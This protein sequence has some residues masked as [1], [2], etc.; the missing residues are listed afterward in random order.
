MC[1]R[2][3]FSSLL[4]PN[5]T[6]SHLL[7]FLSSRK[8]AAGP[9]GQAFEASHE[10]AQV[11][12]GAPRRPGDT[13]LTVSIR[14]HWRRLRQSVDRM[15]GETYLLCFGVLVFLHSNVLLTLVLFSEVLANNEEASEAI[16]SGAADLF[17]GMNPYRRSILT[18][19]WVKSTVDQISTVFSSR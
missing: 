5:G 2:D 8:N 14:N 18:D 17:L 19:F 7:F 13:H 3:H 11:S 16:A 15:S 6:I 4:G 12:S 1:I 10:E 9:K